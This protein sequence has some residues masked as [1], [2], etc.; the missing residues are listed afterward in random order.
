MF[1]LILVKK[2]K[3]EEEGH[4]I[5]YN[6]QQQENKRTNNTKYHTEN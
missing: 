2:G 5:Q 4:T 3:F 1:S 6:G